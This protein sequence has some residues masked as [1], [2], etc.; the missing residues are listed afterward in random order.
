MTPADV[1]AGLEIE[2]RLEAT[3]QILLSE[4][5]ALELAKTKQK[6]LENYTKDRIIKGLAA[7]VE[8]TRS[9]VLAK[10]ANWELAEARIAKLEKQIK[11]C[12][13]Y[14]PSDGMVVYANAANRFSRSNMPQI[15][16]GA[17]VRERQKIFSLPDLSRMRMDAKVHESMITWIRPGFRA[18]IKVDAFPGEALTGVVNAVAPL[19]DPTNFLGSGTKVYS[20][21]VDIE[22]VP[23]GLRPGMTAGVEISSRSSTTCSAYR[24]RPCLPSTTRHR[25]R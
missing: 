1:V 25:S 21:L 20:T 9:D 13:L 8:R 11:N 16:E 15:E 22:E 24:S 5:F 10:R 17:T 14:A 4:G 7:Q 2:D 19:P 18:R 12:M 3:E 6:V 23:A